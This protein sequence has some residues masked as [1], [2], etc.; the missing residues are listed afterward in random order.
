M[1]PAC[2]GKAGPCRAQLGVVGRVS[3]GRTSGCH[4][5]PLPAPS[6]AHSALMDIFWVVLKRIGEGDVLAALR[7]HILQ[8]MLPERFWSCAS[9]LS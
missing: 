8:T 3:K 1:G 6:H 5:I 7:Q 9:K 4:L 2:L